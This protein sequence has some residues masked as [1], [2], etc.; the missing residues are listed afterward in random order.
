MLD[1]GFYVIA[2]YVVPVTE[3]EMLKWSEV[4][5]LLTTE[6]RMCCQQN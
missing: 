6:R 3:M 5:V 1:S 2:G 4:Y